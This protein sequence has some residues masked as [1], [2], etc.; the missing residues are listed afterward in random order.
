MVPAM[1]RDYDQIGRGYAVS[2][3]ADPRIAQ[4]IVNALG[5][6]RTVVNVGA[7]AGSYEP[8][9]LSVVAVEL[10]IEMIRQRPAHAATVVRARA[11]RLPFADRSF[12]AALAVLTI[13]HWH[14]VRSG[15]AELRR[16]A[17]RRVVILTWDPDCAPSF[18]LASYYLP[19]IIELDR[20]RCPTMAELL[21]CLG[22]ARVLTVTVPKD[23]QDGFLG[24]F[25]QRPEAYLDPNVRRGISTFALL[26]ADKVQSGLN[27]L[28]DDLRS[29]LWDERFG[30]L[31]NQDSADLGYRLI[32]AESRN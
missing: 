18:W 5:G 16:V 7:G 4:I 32:V 25:W 28:A 11:E 13:H 3:R 2:R 22:E 12:D 14:N 31:R 29:G 6:A 21:R 9:H 17:R 10:S 15:L 23:C 8:E 27:R 24:A 26:P 19:Q 20:R 30:N 1:P